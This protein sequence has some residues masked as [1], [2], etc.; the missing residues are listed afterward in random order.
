M[1]LT[2]EGFI[3]GNSYICNPES[4]RLL[5]RTPELLAV[6]MGRMKLYLKYALI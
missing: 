4:F 3:K 1:E 2:L 5:S 6:W